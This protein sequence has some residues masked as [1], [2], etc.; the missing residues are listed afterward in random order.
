MEDDKEEKLVHP[1]PWPMIA[2]EEYNL[3]KKL[4]LSFSC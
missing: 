3:Y 4:H 1:F 2:Q